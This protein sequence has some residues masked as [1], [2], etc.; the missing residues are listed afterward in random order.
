MSGVTDPAL[1]GTRATII[2]PPVV[3]CEESDQTTACNVINQMATPQQSS[4]NLV[5]VVGEL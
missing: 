2:S 5:N 3:T 1:L 4:K